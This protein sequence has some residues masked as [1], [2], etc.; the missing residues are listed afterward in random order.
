[1]IS[2]PPLARHKDLALNVDANRSMIRYLEDGGVS[3]LMYGGNA[4]FYNVSVAEYPVVLDMLEELAGE[5]TWIIPSVGADYGKMLDQAAILR[6]RKFPTA[7]LLPLGFPATPDGIAMGVRHFAEAFGKPVVL[8]IKS[9]GYIEPAAAGMLV[10]EGLLSAV[11]YGTVRT[12]PSNDPY[13]HALLDVVDARLIV[14]GIGERPAIVHLRDFGLKAFTSGS[15]CVAPRSSM[16]LLHAIKTGRWEE[17]AEIRA[18]FIPLEDCRD[19]FSPI[20][21]LHDAVTLAGI[22]DMGPMLPMLTNL[23][24]AQ[25]AKVRE[26]ALA[27]KRYDSQVPA[28]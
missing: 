11:K 25:Q 9:D 7:M 15:V 12:N 3:T 20:R 17:A 16:R 28:T 18:A 10:R 4:N 23:P 19:A 14:S 24:A 5:D 27:L 22:A 6:A 1:V 26:A 8:Y 21:T 2:V 13:L